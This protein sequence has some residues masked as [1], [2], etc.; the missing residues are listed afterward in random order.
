MTR[1]RNATDKRLLLRLFENCIVLYVHHGG[2]LER[3]LGANVRKLRSREFT[4]HSAPY[5]V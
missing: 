2:V 4:V 1:F 5:Q 3:P